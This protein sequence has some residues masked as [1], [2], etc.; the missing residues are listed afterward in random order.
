MV[1]GEIYAHEQFYISPESGRYE[2][3][4]ILIL[5]FSRAGDIVG[6]LLTSRTHGRPRN[7]PCFHGNPYPGYFLGALGAPLTAESWLDLRSMG[8]LDIDEFQR[9]CRNGLARRVQVMDQMM[10]LAALECTAGAED[11][12]RAQEQAIRDYIAN[13]RAGR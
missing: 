10:F 11:T 9:D 3:K 4:Y 7:P 8:E 5:A 2:R 6:R 12:T 13:H 1:P